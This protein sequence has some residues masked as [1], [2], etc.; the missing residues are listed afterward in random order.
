MARRSE[1]CHIDADEPEDL[2][3]RW[4]E[5]QDIAGCANFVVTL[6]EL[7]FETRLMTG[8]S[9][10]HVAR[11]RPDDGD[12]TP[13]RPVIQLISH[14]FPCSPSHWPAPAVIPQVLIR[15]ILTLCPRAPVCTIVSQDASHP[16]G[17]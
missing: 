4:P 15:N 14:I 11:P 1:V 6:E 2:L 10:G 13:D 7:D 16:A 17:R 5:V 8:H 9:R 3:R 12:A